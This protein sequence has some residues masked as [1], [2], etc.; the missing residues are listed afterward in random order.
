MNAKSGA[1]ALARRLGYKGREAPLPLDFGRETRDTL[2][3]VKPFTMTSWERLGVLCDA[4]RH[5][6]A[7]SIEG[8]VVECGVWR[9]GS[10][11]A[12]AL[13]LLQLGSH[14]RDLWL[15]DTYAGM[16]EPTE[17]DRKPWEN[18]KAT[19]SRFEQFDRGTHNDWCYASLDDVRSNL[20]STD[21]PSERLH[22][23]EGK[24]EET[25][26]GAIPDSIALLR[27]D[28]DFYESTRAE[29]EYLYPRL[30]PGGIL[31]LDDY[32]EWDGARRAVDEFFDAEPLYLARIDRAARVAVKPTA[33]S[34][35]G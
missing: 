19:R 5:I 25:L 12:S 32:A 30:R 3:R 20:L 14:E 11:M 22:F 27:L 26:P 29:L 28:T 4:I 1:R 18:S 15:Y 31:I 7:A 8:D 16:S 34:Q 23:V 24:V 13:T 10:M 21:Y 33:A 35:A 2:R 6:E 17:I 9:G